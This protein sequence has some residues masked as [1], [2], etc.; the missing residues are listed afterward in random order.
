VTT[1]SVTPLKTDVAP[2]TSVPPDTTSGPAK[3]LV[4]PD[5]VRVPEPVL[6]SPPKPESAPLKVTVR[7]CV[8]STVGPFSPLSSMLSDDDQ[9][10]AAHNATPP[11]LTVPWILV[12]E[13]IPP[14]PRFTSPPFRSIM[15]S[16]MPMANRAVLTVPPLITNEPPE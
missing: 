7:P 4:A 6:T 2:Q 8:S 14:E 9:F 13:I 5:S 1:R 12:V 10:A 16:G 11:S 15:L 3:V